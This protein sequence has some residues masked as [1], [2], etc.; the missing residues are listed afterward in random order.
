MR[1]RRL[2]EENDVGQ[3]EDKKRMMTKV[4]MRVRMR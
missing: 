3:D 1:M 2:S 4:R